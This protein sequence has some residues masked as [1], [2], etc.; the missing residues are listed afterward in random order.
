MFVSHTIW[1]KSLCLL[2]LLA[3]GC[4][5]GPAPE[6]L[7]SSAWMPQHREYISYPCVQRAQAIPTGLATVSPAEM[8]D[9]AQRFAPG[10]RIRV[11]ILGD[12]D[13]LSGI[14]VVDPNGNINMPGIPGIAAAG[15]TETS[16]AGTLRQSLIAANLVRPLSRAVDLR[17]IESG[18]VAVSVT[19]AVFFSGSV[20]VGER[21]A[22]DRIGQREGEASGDA[23]S[24]R[25]VAS[26]LR[27]AGG[28]RPDADI[29]QI[30]LVRGDRQTV[31][32]MTGMVD[33]TRRLNLGITAGDRIIVPS[34]GCFN[35][36]IVRPSPLTAPGIRVHMSNLS[37]PATNNAGAAVGTETTSLPY[38]TRMLQGL[39]AMNCVG[40]SAMNARR[41]AVLISRNPMNGQSIV[42]ERE[43]EE[44]VRGAD[45]DSVDPYLMPGDALACYDS[46]MMN[47]ADAISLVT[48]A[49]NAV[50]PAA[51]LSGAID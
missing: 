35:P 40:G 49:V 24:G 16:V 51:I 22:E 39:V 28:V 4:A 13:R 31:L 26:A 5:V 48:G 2:G 7:S 38:G 25:T 15:R 21:R 3:T 8:V 30:I 19:G 37:R 1:P 43:V 45:R 41:R 29:S 34:T 42:V 18:G 50:A 6:N 11:R 14:Y 36:D 46:R 32:D 10:D 47:F 44:L 20:R 23:N 12:E 17:L 9:G 27:A 33:G